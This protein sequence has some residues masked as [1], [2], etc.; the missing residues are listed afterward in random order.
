MANERRTH[1]TCKIWRRLLAYRT[2]LYRMS[3]RVNITDLMTERPMTACRFSIDPT[4]LNTLESYQAVM[5]E[6]HTMMK[7]I[8]MLMLV[9]IICIAVLTNDSAYAVNNFE[10]FSVLSKV[11]QREQKI[12]HS[13][14]PPTLER[15]QNNRILQNGTSPTSAPESGICDVIGE[16]LFMSETCTCEEG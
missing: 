10:S 15:K 11:G 9:S 2:D 13:L 5:A 12:R 4:K 3:H 16:D 7:V 6:R 1:V 14:H 8:M